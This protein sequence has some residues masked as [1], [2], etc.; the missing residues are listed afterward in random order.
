MNKF[1]NW[2]KS[3]SSDK[4][5]IVIAVI[6]LN[7]VSIR[8]FI[9]LDLTSQKAYSISKASKDVVKHIESPLSIKVFFTS[10]L[11]APYNTIEQYITDILSEYKAHGSK[12]FSYQIFDMNNPQHQKI[13]SEFGLGPVQI[14]TVETTQISSKIA[15]MGL[16]IT[17]GDYI[18]TIDSLKTT[19]DIEYKITTTIS[20]IISTQ[21][22]HTDKLFEIGYLTGHNENQLRA[23]QYAQ[24]YKEVGCQNFS[25]ILSDIYTIKQINL[26]DEDI[27]QNLKTII[28]NNPSSKISE[29][30]FAIL[31]SFISKGGSL[32]VFAGGLEETLTDPNQPPQFIPNQSGI[33]EYL[34]KYGIKIS[35]SM[36]FDEKC[37]EQ[38]SM[39]GR[40]S[41]NWAPVIEKDSTDQKNEISKNLGGLIFFENSPIDVE[42]A[43]NNPDLKT[44]ILAKTTKNTWTQNSGIMLYPGYVNPPADRSSM[45]SEN[46]AVL[47]EGKFNSENPAKIIA[48]SSGLVTIDV[49][50]DR[51]GS[52]PISLFLRNTIDYANGAPDFCTMRTKGKR[53]DF[54]SIKS[55]KFALIIQLLNEFGL[56]VVVA[57]IGFI[58]WRMRKA[59]RYLIQQKYNPND[60]RTISKKTTEKENKNND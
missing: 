43:Q 1:I 36:I 53:L 56:A 15:W 25:N 9:R 52:E 12:Y 51:E 23:N 19:D 24:I 46:V 20:K 28:I 16:A 45:K 40:Q 13:A 7:L 48:V 55:Q 17:Y 44:T 47:V 33:I 35:N 14:E 58:V 5:L 6:L 2:L 3:P 30:E 57:I 54:I 60:E 21:D 34:S 18:A 8:G 37:F 39:Y 4:F 26:A 50:V 41:L 59:K 31:D 49:L 11:P 38:N 10:N 32:V 42:E 22:N 27:P 29:D